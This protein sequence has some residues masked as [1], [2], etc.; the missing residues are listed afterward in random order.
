[1][2]IKRIEGSSYF[3][4]SE[5]DVYHEKN[6]KKLKPKLTASGYYELGLKINGKKSYSVI[7]RIVAKHFIPNPENKPFV[8]HINGIKTDNRVEN[9]EWVTHQE[10]MDHAKRTGLIHKGDYSTSR[11]RNNW[12]N[13]ENLT[14]ETVHEICRLLQN[15]YRNLDIS[16]MTGIKSHNVSLIRSKKCWSHIS[17]LYNYPNKS[18]THSVDTI[19]WVWK[20]MQEGKTQGEIL[21]LANNPNINKYLIQDLRRGLYGDVTGLSR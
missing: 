8:N 11:K 4:T 14:E 19:R 10:N 6:Q 1:M 2:Q 18:R 13:Q 12:D 17:D 20:M 15:G 5:G 16:Q 21:K 9:L 3:I 7:H